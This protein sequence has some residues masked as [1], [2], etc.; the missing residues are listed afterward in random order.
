MPCQPAP[1]CEPTF[2]LFCEPLSTTNDGRRIIVEDSASCQK[3][4]QTT[5][6]PSILKT[7]LAG[8]ISWEGGSTGSVLSYTA[9]NNIE[10]V[11]GSNGDP[12]KLPSTASHT[13]DNV[14]KALVMLADG[15][16]KVW[17]P[18]LTAD[19]FIA[20]WDGGDWRVNTIN[21][22][23]PSGQGVL[24]RDTTDTLQIVPNGISGSSLQ[25]VGTSPQFVAA[26]PNQLPQGYLFGLT[27]ENNGGSP[28]DTL[29]INIGRCRSSDNTSDL[30]LSA[31]IT[32]YANIAWNQGTNE[33][34]LDS[35]SLGSN[36]TW[37][38]YVISNLSIVDVIFSQNGISPTL[39]SGYSLY[40][41]IGSFTTNASAQVR[42]FSQIGNR[43]LYTERPTVSQS[44]VALGIGGNLISLNGI[45]N[46]LRVKPIISSQITAAVS[47]AFYEFISTYPSTQIPGANNTAANTYLRQGQSAAMVG[48]YSLEVYTNTVRQI[49]I[50]VSAA[51]AVGAA[52]LYVDVYGWYDD[53]G[54]SY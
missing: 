25:M 20:Y 40:R 34:G 49:G 48:A 15:T 7:N 29:D 42:Q 19:K 12:L 41:R 51:V 26:P 38:V 1:P 8:V 50:D 14:P 43:F 22:I 10:F 35:G 54:Q 45:P 31:L 5:P 53:R 18:S 30:V 36:Q 39:P 27:I 24:I 33:G 28:F 2:P 16:V 13:L 37:H 52:G 9:S 11:D 6:F 44:G 21:S 4:I 47:W 23:L 3:S 17:E 46:D 32:K